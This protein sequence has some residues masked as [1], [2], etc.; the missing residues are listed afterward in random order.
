LAVQQNVVKGSGLPK[1]EQERIDALHSLQVLDTPTE[2]KFD[3]I[4]NL[5][6]ILFDVP[7]A[8]ISLVDS[9]RQWFKSCAGLNARETPRGVSF[10]SHAILDDSTM[11]ISDALEDPRFADNPLVTGPPHIRFYAGKPIKGPDNHKI[12]TF[13]IIDSKPRSLSKADRKMLNDLAA[14][15]ES[16][17]NTINLNNKLRKMN[18]ELEESIR[19][20]EEL[21]A[22]ISHDLNT[23]L[24]PIVMCSEMLESVTTGPLNEKQER[25]VKT[26]QRCADRMDKLIHDIHDTYKLELKSLQLEKADIN[27]ENLIDECAELIIPLIAEKQIELKTEINTHK[28]IYADKNRLVQVITNL[29]KNSIDFVGETNGRITIR[30]EE[31]D[32]SNILFSVGDNGVGIK[33]EVAEKIFDKFYKEPSSQDRKYGGSGLGL[34]ICKGIVEEHGGKIWVDTS[35]HNGSLIKF[36]IP[37]NI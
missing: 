9:N 24:S 36:T 25:M 19:T 27:L 21:V 20:K 37:V 30:V 10:C 1:N 26:I 16:E 32:S 15:A 8:L 17:L 22:M 3:R 4:T 13:C 2:E 18:S 14:W 34:A 23:P 29:V 35:N 5:A 11:V 6:Q 12:G 7:I 28:R 33:P 31:H